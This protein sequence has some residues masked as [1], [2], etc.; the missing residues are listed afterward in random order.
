MHNP[1]MDV[2]ATPNLISFRRLC[3]SE[4]DHQQSTNTGQCAIGMGGQFEF[5]GNITIRQN[6]VNSPLSIPMC[7]WSIR[8]KN[9]RS[10]RFELTF[11]RGRQLIMISPKVEHVPVR[12]P[13]TCEVDGKTYSGK[14]WVAGKILIVATGLGG[15]SNL[16]RNI[17][18]EG[19]A[20][21]LLL[22]LAKEGK[23]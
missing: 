7:F 14:Y 12:H 16:C 21:Q 15:K 8:D 13:I 4:I 11:Q 23:A 1:P 5:S 2:T 22:E 20:R 18:A 17:P 6:V 3:R 19:Q 10:K 9:F